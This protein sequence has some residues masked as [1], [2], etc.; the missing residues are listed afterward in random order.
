MADVEH[1]IIAKV[2]RDQDMVALTEAR[3]TRDFFIDV[4]HLMVFDWM[5]EHWAKYGV[6][7]S[8]Q[9]LRANYPNYKLPATPEP[10]AYYVDKI[11]HRQRYNVLA[12]AVSDSAELLDSDVGDVTTEVQNLLQS[13]LADVN[14]STSSLLDHNLTDPE[15]FDRLFDHY[16]ALTKDPGALRG[17][18]TGFPTIDM[19]TMGLQPKQLVTLA[20]PPKWGKSTVALCIADN[21]VQ[22]GHDVLLVSFEMSYD[23]QAAR[24]VGLRAKLNYRRL[25]KG[26]MNDFDEKRLDR[27]LEK[28]EK[29]SKKLILSEDISA[30]TTVSGIIAK[31]Q[32]H[33]PALV[34]IDGVYLMEDER[35]EAAGSAAALTNITRMLK[36]AA[37]LY[38]VPIFITTQVLYS[39]MRG[40]TVTERSIGWSSSFVQDSDTVLVGEL[41]DPDVADGGDQQHWLKVV[42][43]RSGPRA[44]CQIDFD[45]STS[46]FSEFATEYELEDEDEYDAE[47][48]RG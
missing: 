10:M 1:Q 40:N 16:A 46:T 47:A 36:R 19:A 45:W 4:E 15:E 27:V 21:V 43:S 17:L 34:I 41:R 48:S 33:K 31:I 32:Q 26:K 44:E 12:E 14:A 23:E 6:A 9:A 35:G 20:G 8:E 2:I 39:K 30:T 29:G 42:A 5:A 3:I 28:L 38:E 22:A 18:P 13:A 37:Q 24:W 11:R 7:P 25:L